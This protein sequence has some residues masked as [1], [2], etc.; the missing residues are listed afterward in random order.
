MVTRRQLAATVLAAFPAYLLLAEFSPALAFTAERSAARRWILMQD[1]IAGA[2]ARGDM[3]PRQW[4]REVSA[5]CRSVD[6]DQLM[7]E[8][9]RSRVRDVGRGQANDPHK[10][11]ILFRDETGTPRRLHYAAALFGFERHNVITPHAHRHM[12]SAHLVVEGAFRVRNYD[13]VRNEDG[14]VIIRPSI[15]ETIAVGDVSTIGIERDNIHWFVPRSERATTFDIIVS[16][17]DEDAPHY[18]IEAVDP[19]RGTLLPD[20]TVRAPILDFAEAG[21]F[22]TADL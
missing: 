8:I 7:A 2:L 22:Y 5:L 19:V 11:S 18:V 21:R 16:G 14:A 20:G 17:L 12:V 10:R 3:S 13:R 4:R 1:E 6:L 9:G 15:D